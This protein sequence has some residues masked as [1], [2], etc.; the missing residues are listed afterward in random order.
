MFA[1]G[2]PSLFTIDA[3]F[4]KIAGSGN[5]TACSKASKLGIPDRV[6]DLQ[7]VNDRLV[8]VDLEGLF[9][10]PFWAR[11]CLA[12]TNLP[13]LYRALWQDVADC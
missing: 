2:N 8:Y 11:L 6:T 10:H 7:A 12:A 5:K 13:P 3:G 4:D 1:Y 9:R